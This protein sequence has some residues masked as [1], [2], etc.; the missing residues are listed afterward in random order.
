M[1]SDSIIRLR[2]VS[3]CYQIYENPR[4]RLLQMLMRG[5]KQ[6]F[7]E[8]WALKDLS[9]KVEPG[10]VIGIIGRNGSGKS[11]LLQLICGTLSPTHGDI[12]V[13][14]RVAALLEL[15]AGFN[16]DFSGRENIYLNATLSGL[17]DREIQA[18]MNNIIDFS[19]IRDFIDQPVKTYSS[20]MYVRL[21]F[22]VAINVDPDILVIDEALAVGDGEFSRRS[23]DRIMQLRDAGKTILFCSHSLYQVEA[24]CDHVI[25][26]DG[27]LVIEQGETGKV[28]HAYSSYLSSMIDQTKN[29]LVDVKETSPSGSEAQ[30]ARLSLV[31]LSMNDLPASRNIQVASCQDTVKVKV[32]FESDLAYAIPSVGIVIADRNEKNITSA[33]SHID[34]FSIARSAEGKSC[35]EATF[36]TF[37]LLKGEYFV[38]V[39]LLCERGIH[40]Y[41]YANAFGCITVTQNHLEQGVVSIPHC[42]GS[43]EA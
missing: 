21:A 30:I 31:E 5:R 36:P 22:S 2:N 27:G 17:S 9:L 10:E 41:D 32:V 38:Y 18:S 28:T 40:V 35:V 6:Y 14:G 3:K 7:R 1:S 29:E 4:D 39:F 26:L 8:F 37:P 43:E 15:G 34:E 19:G 11:T 24:L 23:F 12:E 16:P 42:W 33:G 20:G 25:W 13:K